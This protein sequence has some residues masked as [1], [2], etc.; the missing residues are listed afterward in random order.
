MP[1][2]MAV[3]L[4]LV[5]A[6]GLGIA[7]ANMKANDSESPEQRKA[8]PSSGVPVPGGDD[9]PPR[10][11]EPRPGMLNLIKTSWDRVEVLGE[12]TVRVHFVGGQEP[13]QVLDHVEVEYRR[14]EILI[15][16]H[17]G[18]DPE[19][20]GNLICESIGLFK[21]VDVELDEAPKDRTFVDGGPLP[22]NQ[23]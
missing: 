22:E 16:L 8:D 12:R 17:E 3:M 6:A 20:G 1:K 19:A 9:G 2:L 11:V 7:G 18:S 5:L 23:D 13:C 10:L 14:T 4:G 15:T 21:A